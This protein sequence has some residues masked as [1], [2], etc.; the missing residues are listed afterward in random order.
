MLGLVVLIVVG[1]LV[2]WIA[3][4]S[5]LGILRR[6]TQAAPEVA[7]PALSLAPGYYQRDV[8]LEIL[9]PSG[10]VEVR[11]T[12]DGRLPSATVGEIYDRP[13]LLRAGIPKVT[14]VRARAVLPDGTLG[15]EVSASYVTAIATT[16]PVL[17]LIVDPGDLWDEARGI[18]ANPYERGIAWERPAA[19]TY[20]DEARKLGFHIPAGVR[21]HGHASRSFEKK[22]LRLYFRG[23]YGATELAYPLFGPALPVSFNRLV[24]HS[25]GQDESIFPMWNWTLI[26]NPLA[27]RLALSI[28]LYPTRSRPV[29][30]F[31]NGELWGIYHIR[32]RIDDDYFADTLGIAAA[33]VLDAPDSALEE[34]VA[35]DREHWES[36]LQFVESHS[37]VDPEPYAYV[38]SQ[39]DLDTFIDYMIL[40]IYGA[41]A[42]WPYHNVNQFRA[43]VPGGR[44]Q[45]MMWDSD[46]SFGDNPY[47]S[48]VDADMIRFLLDERHPETGGRDTVL[49][50]KLM[51][52]PTFRTRFLARMAY[53]LNTELS[54]SSVIA[55][56]DA[57]AAELKPDIH[58]EVARWLASNTWE[59]NVAQLRDF[60]QRRPEVLRRHVAAAFDL[61]G[62]AAVTVVPPAMG[63]GTVAVEGRLVTDLPWQGIVFQDVPLAITA[64]PAPGY[65]F[66]GWEPA[67]L[68]QTPALSLTLFDGLS[69]TRTITPRFERLGEREAHAGDVVITDYHVG[70]GEAGDW[71][72]LQV[73][74]WRGV[75]LRGWRITDNDTKVATDEGSL[76]FPDD[77]VF[78]RVPYG[79]TIRVI[80][81]PEAEGGSPPPDDLSTFDHQRVLYVANGT[82]DTDRDPWFDLGPAD[83]IVLLAPGPTA[84][85]AD[86]WG[87]DLVSFG[88]VTPASFGVLTDGVRGTGFGNP[89]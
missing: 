14:V 7:K 6:Q 79:T 21:I 44:W 8:F 57:L 28:G 33:D 46:H 29:L 40:N 15:P 87:I 77:P 32:E 61:G 43:R 69:L 47:G 16:L 12:L 58:Y 20:V 45:W 64:A 52:N 73:K 39:V 38:Q 88:P 23:S 36:L 56:I 67:D 13:I 35:G 83:N 17:S 37:L 85:F 9:P 65:R 5:R 25:G 86:D 31:L 72:E 75:D 4:G 30:L 70:D 41:N 68:P 11:F 1:L 48:H 82:L 19:V 49:W 55:Q 18:Y 22:S 71:F 89:F 53:L 42:N 60:A 24:L 51:E 74:R 27:D 50:R 34:V 81:D 84:N 80:T 78:A 54:A 10:A 63:R 3:P 76:I 26:R 66:V 59:A 2:L 62:T